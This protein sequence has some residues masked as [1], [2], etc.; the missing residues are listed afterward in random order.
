[1]RAKDLL[2]LGTIVSGLALIGEAAQI[3]L[4]PEFWDWLVNA[5]FALLRSDAVGLLAVVTAI[6]FLFW[7]SSLP[8]R[9]ATQATTE[10]RAELAAKGYTVLP[11]DCDTSSLLD[12]SP[13]GPFHES[14]RAPCGEPLRF[15]STNDS[16]PKA[17]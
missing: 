16:G 1:M 7:L 4:T 12:D 2:L 10:Q 8:W 13:R 5:G 11:A 17:A 14:F 15:P 6:L 9:Q 3:S